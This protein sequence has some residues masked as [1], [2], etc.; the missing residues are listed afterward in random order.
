MTFNQVP[1]KTLATL[2]ALS[3]NP[4]TAKMPRKRIAYVTTNVPIICKLENLD[5]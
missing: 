1:S 4:F 2:V 5:A 3:L